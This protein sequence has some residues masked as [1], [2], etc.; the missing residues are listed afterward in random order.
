[1]SEVIPELP[2]ANPLTEEPDSAREPSDCAV[3]VLDLVKEY[4][5]V[6]AVDHLSFQVPPG[7]IYGV[8]GPNGAGKT[9]T[10][11]FLATLLRPTSGSGFIHGVS[12]LDD[13][14]EVRRLVGYMPEDFGLYDGMKVWEY[15]DFFAAAYGVP[16]TVR[17]RVLRDVVEL[18]DL[19]GKWDDFASGLSRG[20]RQRLALA[21]ALL[22]DPRVLVLDEPASGLDPRARLEMKEL[23]RE[24]KRM[25]KTIVI[26]SHILS[27]LADLCDMVAVLEK[28][29][30][31]IAGTL[32]GLRREL[33]AHRLI[34]ISVLDDG[35]ERAEQLLRGHGAVHQVTRSG[36][37]LLVEVAGDDFVLAELLERLVRERL[38]VVKFA[39][40]EL[41]LEE[42]FMRVT[43]GIVA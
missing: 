32:E 42:I 18:L 35:A 29:R 30:L 43:R 11:R 3:A 2:S 7:V 39:E 17:Q 33:Q 26:S 13:P 27:E 1:M 5:N 12:I 16:R 4:R 31:V 40:R 14:L 41:T 23:V 21:R 15:L 9:T 38:C 8:I 20:M 19:D 25:G 22:H 34:D 37:T 10:F 28:G 6:R 36:N 24:L